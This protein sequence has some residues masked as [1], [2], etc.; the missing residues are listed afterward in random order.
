MNIKDELS[1]KISRACTQFTLKF[2][3]G[4]LT[5]SFW[6]EQ[7][8]KVCK[9]TQESENVLELKAILAEFLNDFKKNIRMLIPGGAYRSFY[10]TLNNI[11]L[12]EEYSDRNLLKI[13]AEEE[14]TVVGHQVKVMRTEFRSTVKKI[15]KECKALKKEVKD[16]GEEV[17]RLKVENQLLL[18][19]LMRMNSEFNHDPTL[20]EQ[21]D[22]L[23]RQNQRLLAIISGL[24]KRPIHAVEEILQIADQKENPVE[25]IVTNLQQ[26]SRKHWSEESIT[27]FSESQP[28]VLSSLA[29]N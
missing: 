28:C 9:M 11:L 23:K 18:A 2:F 19:A 25:D 17:G 4:V 10:K 26:L 5:P 22:D 6:T 20:V 16:Q 12:M 15:S 29:T 27:F 8:T 1:L 3:T 24:V 21:V 13:V 7:V 14:K